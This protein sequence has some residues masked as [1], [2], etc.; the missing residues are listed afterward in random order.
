VAG[1]LLMVAGLVAAVPARA[2]SF[3]WCDVLGQDFVTPVKDQGSTGE[4]WAF[5][6]VAALE[7]KYMITRNDPTYDPS[8]SEQQLVDAAMG[9]VEGGNPGPALQYFCSTGELPEQ[10]VPFTGDAAPAG[11]SMPAGWQNQVC[12][13][14]SCSGAMDA[15]VAEMKSYL[16]QDGPIVATLETDN[17]WY[18]PSGGVFRGWHAALIV[19]YQD[20]P[21][22]SG[23]GY[24]ILK[25]S[26]GTSWG[27]AGYGEIAYSVLGTGGG[28][29]F[30]LLSGAAYV[31][32]PLAT[33][34]WQGGSGAWS[35]GG[36]TN[37]TSGGSSYAWQNQETAAVFGA[38]G[39]T[40]SI[41]VSGTAIAYGL[42]INPGATGYSFSGGALTL[43][44]GGIVANE[45]LSIGSP[46][47]I[48]APQSWVT[49]AGKTLTVS[50]GVNT[51]IST[52]TV[53]GPGTTLIQGNIDDGGVINS[54]GA[55]GGGVTKQGT[56]TLVLS[57]N[58]TYS[59]QTTLDGG[60]L[61]LVGAGALNPLLTLG[62]FNIE[63]GTLLIDYAGQP[64]PAATID[65]L[66]A[67]GFTASWS[68]RR[69]W[70]SATAACNPGQYTV[71]WSDNTA[72]SE[73]T[74]AYTVLGDANLDG[75]VDVN[76]L[77]IVLSNF[78]GTDMSWGQGD[79]TY[80]GLVD[81]NDLTIVLSNWGM[82]V[83]S[84]G[85]GATAV[86]EPSSVAMLL[87]V[88]VALAMAIGLGP[89]CRR[90]LNG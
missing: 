61:E 7:A 86:P 73:I 5:S 71:G 55:T 48:G 39:A 56:G 29:D 16:L 75:T 34:A 68:T 53:D 31:T 23:G 72:A 52:L 82:S 26:W 57:G 58:N 81:I 64:D 70:C 35:A 30:Y 17:D 25:N 85:S 32:G 76:D 4:C 43:D 3:N 69:Q 37:W 46:I 54:L 2:D 83:G 67:T 60:T 38:G 18:Y 50:G 87:G 44:H 11:W 20:N 49:A 79:F 78:G 10:T 51:V 14:T 33:A 6:T 59:G 63:A 41:A 24:W 80:D 84:S 28:R 65:S 1:L 8:F 13:A 62:G 27:N 42:T 19:G 88:G 74:V 47:T 77:T 15:D 40:N 12:V 36:S 9:T 89:T 45:S 66:L 90:R 21:S 22:I